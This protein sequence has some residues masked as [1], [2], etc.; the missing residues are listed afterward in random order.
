M[1]RVVLR[2]RQT[3]AR[4]AEGHIRIAERL[5]ELFD[6]HEA[7]VASEMA[8]HYEEAGSWQRAASALR[9]AARHAQQR[10]AYREAEQL[11]ERTLRIAENLNEDDR[12]I[13]SKEVR[14]ELEGVREA[15]EYGAG[16]SG[17]V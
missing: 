2:E 7:D 9:D 10:A 8:S 17:I 12:G 1:Y 16:A 6:G 4:R 5:R 11:L 14:S 13:L 3:A 15:I